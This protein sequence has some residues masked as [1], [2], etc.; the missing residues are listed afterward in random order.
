MI[1]LYA[2]KGTS[3]Y[4]ICITDK[5]LPKNELNKVIDKKAKSLL[6]LIVVYQMLM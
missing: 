2:G 4:K 1:E 6:L 3:K 5:A